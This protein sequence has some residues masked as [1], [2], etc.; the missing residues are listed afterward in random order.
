MECWFQNVTKS[1]ATKPSAT[2]PT[3]DPYHFRMTDGGIVINSVTYARVNS[4]EYI[5]NRNLKEQYYH[6]DLSANKPF[7]HIEG[8]R[9]HELKV[10][11]T[12]TNTALWDLLY[13][14]TA[15]TI[16]INFDR[17]ATSDEFTIT[18]KNCVLDEG[19]HGLPKDGPVNVDL[20]FRPYTSGANEA[21][22]VSVIDSNPYFG[23]V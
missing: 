1:V 21:V 20:V 12:V 4:F 22:S 7:E 5:L 16:T 6:C 10:N 15:V 9:E 2:I 3:T 23:F 19:M 18:W 13:A 8:I 14:R 17:T 11:L